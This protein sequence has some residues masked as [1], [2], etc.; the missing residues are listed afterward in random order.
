MASS[1][2]ILKKNI[3][4]LCAV[5]FLFLGG[6]NNWKNQQSGSEMAPPI[7]D[8]ELTPISASLAGYEDI[9]LPIEMKQ[10]KNMAIRTGS[11]RGG[12]YEYVG[13]VELHS[14][15]DY[16]ANSMADKG[17]NLVGEADYDKV[18]LAFTKPSKTCLVVLK[19]GSGS[20]YGKTYANFYV[21]YDIAAAHHLTP[22]GERE[23]KK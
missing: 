15:R 6:C 17:W 12:V 19:N 18:M 22:F 8:E 4:C 5:S 23:E 9:E 7:S 20:S 21:T 3:I 14:L 1:I 10:G 13:K 2:F 16:I 11:F